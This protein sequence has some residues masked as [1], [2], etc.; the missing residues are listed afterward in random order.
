MLVCSAALGSATIG[1]ALGAAPEIADAHGA[2]ADG[3]PPAVLHLPNPYPDQGPFAEREFAGSGGSGGGGKMY[4][5][6]GP[7][8]GGLPN[9]YVI[10]YGDWNKTSGSDTPAGQQIVRDF[11]SSIG[12]SPYFNINK[13]YSLST[14]PITGNV[15]YAGDITSQYVAPT[16][17][18]SDQDVQ[19]IVA[20]AFGAG[21]PVDENG[22]YFVLTASDVKK[23]GFCVS[24]CGWHTY[25][26]Y[27]ASNIKY[28]FVGNPAQCMSSCSAQN[29][30][31]NGNAAVDAMV[32]VLAH[33]LEE[34]VTDP[35]LNAWYDMFGYENA[36]KCAWTYGTTKTAPNGAKYNMVLNG[37]PYLIQRNW[38]NAKGGSCA[39]SYP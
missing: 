11:L 21:L 5:R 6:G 24:Y 37:K 2:R 10:W 7:V 15:N 16:A 25:G 18:L 13:T 31:P 29:V 35:N 19:N 9:A 28:S 30:G 39:L 27:G 20:E 3:P 34:A 33:E 36:D 38:V 26:Y 12:G 1:A 14:T 32:S 8:M 17:T 22:V 23:D 4:Y